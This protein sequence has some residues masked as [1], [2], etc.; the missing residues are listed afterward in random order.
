[1]PDFVIPFQILSFSSILARGP[2]SPV[3]TAH[4]IPGEE[5]RSAKWFA[6]GLARIPPSANRGR[7]SGEF[8]HGG[9]EISAEWERGARGEHVIERENSWDI[10]GFRSIA[11]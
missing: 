3:A 7:N 1:F 8:R 4:I 11:W 6:A 5:V 9:C 10:S 2:S